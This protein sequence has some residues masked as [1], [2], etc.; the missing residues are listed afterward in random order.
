VDATPTIVT[1]VGGCGWVGPTEAQARRRGHALLV[2]RAAIPGRGRIAPG[3][4]KVVVD[5]GSQRILGVHVAGAQ[6]R[7]AVA[8]G[9]VLVEHGL[10]RQDL[11]RMAFPAGSPAQALVEAASSAEPA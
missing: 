11:A 3:F 7:E 6:G 10:S 1:G 8:L 4:A 5:R 9:A 2:G